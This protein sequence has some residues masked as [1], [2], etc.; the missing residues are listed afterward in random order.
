MKDRKQ[1]L[2]DT[3]VTA[4][5]HGISY[6]A[7]VCDYR[8][9]NNPEKLY[10]MVRIQDAESEKYHSITLE[11]VA[12]GLRRICVT[13]EPIQLRDDIYEN[14]LLANRTNGAQGDI[15]AECA[16]VIVQ[17]GLFGDVIYG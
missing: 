3:V 1:F 14:I 2:F 16:D 9:N 8:W 17:V 7:I 5:E 11:T 15:D 4:A 10:A 13:G 12:K 6:W